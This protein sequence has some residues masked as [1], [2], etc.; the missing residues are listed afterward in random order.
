MNQCNEEAVF[1]EWDTELELILH[2]YKDPPQTKEL[3]ALARNIS[4]L[5]RLQR[6]KLILTKC[7]NLRSSFV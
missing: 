7:A 1:R 6:L 4:Q 5:D 3:E 2:Y